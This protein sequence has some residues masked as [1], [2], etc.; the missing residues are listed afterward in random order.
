MHRS[1][2]FLTGAITITAATLVAC[3]TPKNPPQLAAPFSAE[4]AFES[5]QPGDLI[6]L[7]IWREPDLSGDY[8]ADEA[9]IVV[10]PLLGPRNVTNLPTDSLKAELIDDFAAYLTHRSIMV[11]PMRR[12]NVLGAVN[13]PGLHPVDATM[14]IADVLALAGGTTSYGNP[15]KV[16]LLRDGERISTRLSQQTLIGQLPIRSGDQLFVPDRSWISRNAGVVSTLISATV[17]IVLA[18]SR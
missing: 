4:P 2:R 12:I 7:E 9:G 8:V 17:S 15:D 1:L 13:R 6:R 3:S 11:T 14:T 16:D 10:L 18:L 5:L